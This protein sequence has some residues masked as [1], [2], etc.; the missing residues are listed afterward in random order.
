MIETNQVSKEV[1]NKF[2]C[3]LEVFELSGWIFYL[4]SMIPR[5]LQRVLQQMW[6]QRNK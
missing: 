6:G 3:K 5:R 4:Y 1:R 2:V